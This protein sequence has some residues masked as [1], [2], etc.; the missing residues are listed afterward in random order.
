M[1]TFLIAFSVF[2]SIMFGVA[3]YLAC[4]PVLYAAEEG[5]KK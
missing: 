3:I 1:E 4:G 2:T 5:V